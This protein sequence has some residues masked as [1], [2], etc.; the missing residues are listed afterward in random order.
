M[1]NTRSASRVFAALDSRPVP[2]PAPAPQPTP[3]RR[4]VFLAL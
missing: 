1:T 2:A 3:N 4:R